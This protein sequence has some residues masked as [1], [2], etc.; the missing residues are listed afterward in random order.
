MFVYL[1]FYG[2]LKKTIKGF[3][4]NTNSPQIS[5][6]QFCHAYKTVKLF[7]YRYLQTPEDSL[8]KSRQ[9]ELWIYDWIKPINQ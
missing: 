6:Y 3:I 1:W 4:D 8:P 7:I 5:I 9:F 2:Y